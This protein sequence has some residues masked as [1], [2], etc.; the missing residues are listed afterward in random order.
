[1]ENN[2]TKDRISSSSNEGEMALIAAASIS[3]VT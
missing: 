1:M 2:Y 3:K